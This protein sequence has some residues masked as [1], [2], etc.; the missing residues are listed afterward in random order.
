MEVSGVVSISLPAKLLAY[1]RPQHI[2][3][4]VGP[5]G[6]STA[7]G[8]GATHPS[9]AARPNRRHSSLEPRQ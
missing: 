1:Q 2:G 4:V 9:P 6:N 5:R 8:L 7:L 3:V